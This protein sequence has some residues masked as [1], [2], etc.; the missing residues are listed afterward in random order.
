MK[1]GRYY[2]ILVFSLVCL[3]GH[4]ILVGAA[5]PQALATVDAAGNLNLSMG[6]LIVAILVMGLGAGAIKACVSPL[7]AEQY[8]GKLRKE[9]L[10][11]G[12][13]ILKSPAIT[14]QSIYLWFYLF[15]NLGSCGA[16][17]ASF[18]A[19]DNGYWAAFLVPTCIF[20]LVPFTLVA[21]KV[22]DL[23]VQIPII[24]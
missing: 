5:S 4:I 9:T 12:E 10:A 22:S 11:S 15:I 7:I 8:T 21:A 3:A 2:T 1:L 14:F 6:L 13:V 20:I 18:L 17:S 19:R 24:P 16:I 23:S